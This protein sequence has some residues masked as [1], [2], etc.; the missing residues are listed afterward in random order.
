[1]VWGGLFKSR[2]CSAFVRDIYRCFGF[3]FPRK[4]R[5]TDA[6][7]RERTFSLTGAKQ[8]GAPAFAGSTA[9]RFTAVFPGH[10]MLYLGKHKDD[11]YVIHAIAYHGEKEKERYR[12]QL[13]SGV[14]QCGGGQSPFSFAA[15]GVGRS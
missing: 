12:W 10:V 8:A 2:D 7:A 13:Y 6:V 5:R 1:M 9:L 14:A 15:A 11:Y 4:L 3:H